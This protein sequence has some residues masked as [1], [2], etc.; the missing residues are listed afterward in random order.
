MV[1]ATAQYTF[2]KKEWDFGH[3]AK[4][5]LLDSFD[6]ATRFVDTPVCQTVFAL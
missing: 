5:I 3:A 2:F 6:T 1:G 4:P